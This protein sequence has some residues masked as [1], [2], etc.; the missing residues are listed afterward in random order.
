MTKGLCGWKALGFKSY[1][2]YV[3]SWL[4]KDKNDFLIELKEKCE[5]CGSKKNLVVHHLNYERVGNE[6]MR[7]LMVVCS[8]C[9]KEIHNG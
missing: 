6:G 2:E 9:H 5:K 7:D 1:E 4:W 3:N 8:K